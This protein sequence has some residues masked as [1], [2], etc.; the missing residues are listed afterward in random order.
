LPRAAN[1]LAPLLFNEL[2][3]RNVVK[4]TQRYFVRPQWLTET[5]DTP[6]ISITASNFDVSLQ[7]L[8]CT[9]EDLT[10]NLDTSEMLRILPFFAL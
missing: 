6:P 3:N 2:F 9:L 1:T 8:S 4:D 10:L 5:A 7:Q